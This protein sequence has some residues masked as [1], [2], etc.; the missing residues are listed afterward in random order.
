MFHG[1]WCKHGWHLSAWA[2]PT[3][4]SVRAG[5]VAGF[6]QGIALGFLWLVVLGSFALALWY[7]GVRV[8]DHAYQGEL[9]SLRLGPSDID[10]GQT[11]DIHRI[12][13]AAFRCAQLTGSVKL[14]AS[15]ALAAAHTWPNLGAAYSIGAC[16]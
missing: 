10:G 1:F 7:G 2:C 4:L 11:S 13:R 9:A 8:R 14:P 6:Y 12:F 16:K 5:I 15:L 3:L